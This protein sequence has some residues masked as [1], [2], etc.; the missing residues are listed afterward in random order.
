MIS[1]YI[2]PGIPR[3]KKKR[4]EP[5][6]YPELDKLFEIC[7]RAYGIHP[8]YARRSRTRDEVC[9]AK[10]AYCYFARKYYPD[11][12]VDDV[13]PVAGYKNHASVYHG[14]AVAQGFIEVGDILFIA[15]F[16]NAEKFVKT[17]VNERRLKL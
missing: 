6:R 12:P 10:H 2:Y 8:D 13:A 11:I 4:R 7:C 1:P 14:E 5:R 15:G 16:R 17:L 9:C 3:V